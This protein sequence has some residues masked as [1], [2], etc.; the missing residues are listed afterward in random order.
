MMQ[1]EGSTTIRLTRFLIASVMG[2]ALTL[3]IYK[4]VPAQNPLPLPIRLNVGSNQP[5]TAQDG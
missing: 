3:V 4:Q 5:Y 1:L 2:L